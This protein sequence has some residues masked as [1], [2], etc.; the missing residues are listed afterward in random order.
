MLVSEKG[1]D[2]L[3]ALSVVGVRRVLTTA[4]RHTVDVHDNQIIFMMT[5]ISTDHGVFTEYPF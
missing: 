2:P 5:F 1:Y 3:E 4:S